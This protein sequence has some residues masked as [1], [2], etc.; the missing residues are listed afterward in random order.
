M[1][2]SEIYLD[3]VEKIADRWERRY[4]FIASKALTFLQINGAILIPLILFMTQISDLGLDV[5][6][7]TPMIIFLGLSSL[8]CI[9]IILPI[10]FSEVSI[11]SINFDKIDEDGE[12]VIN[13]HLIWEYMR[14]VKSLKTA[15]LI[16]GTFFTTA[17]LFFL[18]A[19]VS[20]M[21]PVLKIN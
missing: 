17:T 16:K 4:D 9:I 15:Y 6:Q 18:I 10:K 7:L 13:N 19:L 5:A 12:N 8:S 14:R 20:L 21:I 2:N 1:N 3:Q 11:T